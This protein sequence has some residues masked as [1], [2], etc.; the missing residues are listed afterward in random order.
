MPDTIATNPQP[1]PCADI[2]ATDRGHHLYVR[3]WGSGPPVVL[4]GG[5]ATESSIWGATMTVLNDRGFRTLAYDRRGHGRSTD[6]GN[7]TYDALAD[8]LA[9][10]LSCRELRDVVL[11]AHSGAA[12]EAI[13]YATRHGRQRL[14]RLVLVGATGPCMRRQPDNP[15]GLPD[16][17]VDAIAHQLATDL[18][19]WIDANAE[20]FAP[21]AT[22]RTLDWIAAMIMNTS[23]RSALGFQREIVNADLRAEVAALD[24]PVTMIHGDRDASAPLELT[25]RRYA[26]LIPGAELIVYPDVAHGVMVT[27][28][29]RLA[30][31]IARIGRTHHAPER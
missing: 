25:A 30:E 24:L 26:E 27:H 7:Y 5:W 1:L 17:V 4:L 2:V 28:A 19:G 20:P 14:A 10:V 31:D 8:D 6:P 12:G 15:L 23:R 9:C 3:D 16:D 13:R 21:G 29:Q 11:V 22:R 18:P